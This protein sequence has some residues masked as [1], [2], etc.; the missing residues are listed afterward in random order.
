MADKH[1]ILPSDNKRLAIIG[2]TGSG[3]TQAGVFHLSYRS[4]HK[5][6]WIVVDFKGD[7]LIGKLPY[8][9]EIRPTDRLPKK[10]GLYITRPHPD[11][12]EDLEKLYMNIWERERIGVFVDEAFMIGKNSR[13]FHA[14]LTQGRSK[15]IPIISC[16]QRPVFLD[17]FLL[18]QSEYFQVFK[19]NDP[20]DIKRVRGFVGQDID[21]PLVEYH[22]LW[23]DLSQGAGWVWRPVP[24]ESEILNRFDDRLDKPKRTSI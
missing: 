9:D 12:K 23:Y 2:N 5:Q 8:K 4:W 10:P 17:I 13:G 7:E 16:C 14:L 11:D 21:N 6:P 19:L 20:N 18:S 22:S 1:V 3:K 24:S 15:H